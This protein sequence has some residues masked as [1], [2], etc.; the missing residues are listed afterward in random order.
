MF[1]HL[2]RLRRIEDLSDPFADYEAK[3]PPGRYAAFMWTFLK[4]IT[5]IM[6]G[7]IGMGLMVALIET[8]LIHY[9]GRVVDMLAEAAETAG[10]EALWSL[11]GLELL[12]IALFVLLLRPI[13]IAGQMA[14][15]N[16][17]VSVNLVALV[18]WRTHRHVLGQSVGFFQNDFA[19]R[20]A[21]RIV[22]TAPAVEDSA[23]GALEALVY[24]VAY[25]AGAALVLGGIDWRLAIPIALWLLVYGFILRSIVPR[26]ADAAEAASDRRSALTGKIV[27]GYTNIETVKLFAHAERELTL[28]KDAIEEVRDADARQMR[29]MTLM[30]VCLALAGG[31]LITSTVGTAVWLWTGGA[32]SLGAV[33][34]ASALTLRL[35]SMMGW[36]MWVTSQLFQHAGVIREGMETISRP[37]AIVDAPEA[38]PLAVAR[39]EIRFEGVRHSYGKGAGRGGLDGVELTIRPGERVG[40]VGRSGAG[41]SSLVNLLLRFHDLEEGRILIDGQD[42]AEVTQDSLRRAIGM[43]TQDPSLLHRSVR[44]NLLYGRPEASEA[45]MIAAAEKAR[46]HAFIPDLQDPAGRRGYEAQVG[47][48]GVRL[49][50][51][52]RQR[53]ALARVVLKDAPILVLDEATS[54]LDSEVEAAIQDALSDLMRGKTVIAIAHRLS[55]IAT[56]DRIVVLDEGRVIEDGP[57]D[58]LLA[59]GG[60][61]ARLWARQTGGFLGLDADVKAAE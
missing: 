58:D 13:A 19:G 11:R 33:A 32:A 16:Q 51:G 21:N 53:I 48:R 46:A 27:D 59:K 38:K 43:V 31:F 17:G 22:Q 61:Y 47:E 55:T 2:E 28:A 37:H 6:L 4:P 41:K 7:A 34:A 42:V 60:L 36:I 40:L 39:G 9:A 20:I 12:G 29:L 57:H 1:R 30:S 10:P 14:L 49:S 8:G 44:D 50:G 35:N 25:V 3:T 15:L 54:A 18:R 5:P 56:L 23:Y 52:Q 24:F 26:M 45:E